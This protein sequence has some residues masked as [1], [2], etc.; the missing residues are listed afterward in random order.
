MRTIFLFIF[1]VIIS[2]LALESEGTTQSRSHFPCGMHSSKRCRTIEGFEAEK[3]LGC[4]KANGN[5][6]Y[7]FCH[8]VCLQ[9]A[10]PIIKDTCRNE[11]PQPALLSR[12]SANDRISLY[13]AVWQTRPYDPRQ[14]LAEN[15]TAY[16]RRHSPI[17][18]EE[19]VQKI[20]R[21]HL[22]KKSG[23]TGLRSRVGFQEDFQD[24]LNYLKREDD[25]I[26]EGYRK[27]GQNIQQ[28]KEHA[29]NYPEA[30]Q[31]DQDLAKRDIKG[32]FK[33][34]WR[35]RG[36]GGIGTFLQPFI[37]QNNSY[38][39]VIIHPDKLQNMLSERRLFIANKVTHKGI[40]NLL[41]A[42]RTEAANAGIPVDDIKDENTALMI[43]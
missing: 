23:Q 13:K 18:I 31:A 35:K 29:R 2:F 41:P 5:C 43:N 40:G 34:L 9:A 6:L 27:V 26:I 16:H 21:D 37:D 22:L 14:S 28:E 8:A 17:P 19:A 39:N 7:Q 1:G 3:K 42:L 4:V 20:L 38:N 15:I 24:I 36:V 30:A 12:F 11:C 33:L 32:T 25:T 10:D